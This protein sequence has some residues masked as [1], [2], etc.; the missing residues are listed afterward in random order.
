MH[1]TPLHKQPFDWHEPWY[2]E[3]ENVQG[4]FMPIIYLEVQMVESVSELTRDV[5]LMTF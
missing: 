5:L 1:L 3:N 4:Q 2:W